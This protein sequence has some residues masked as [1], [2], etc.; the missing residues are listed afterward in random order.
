MSKGKRS[1]VVNHGTSS[2]SQLTCG[3]SRHQNNVK[4]LW[5]KLTKSRNTTMDS[6]FGSLESLPV[7]P[8]LEATEEAGGYD[9]E[10]DLA[11]EITDRSYVPPG[12]KWVTVEWPLEC[13]H[14]ASPPS[15]KWRILVIRD[16]EEEFEEVLPPDGFSITPRNRET[17]INAFIGRIDQGE[18]LVARNIKLFGRVP[19]DMGN[20]TAVNKLTSINGPIGIFRSMVH[21]IGPARAYRLICRAFKEPFSADEMFAW[22]ESGPDWT[23]LPEPDSESDDDQ[24]QLASAIIDDARV[25][26]DFQVDGDR[27]LIEEADIRDLREL[28]VRSHGDRR[29]PNLEWE[30]ASPSMSELSNLADDENASGAHESVVVPDPDLADIL[31]SE[32]DD[33][34]VEHLMQRDLRSVPEASP[35]ADDDNPGESQERLI[36]VRGRLEAMRELVVPDVD[37]EEPEADEHDE[38][39]DDEG[40]D[41]T[42]SEWYLDNL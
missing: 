39:A 42:D 7:P 33:P 38:E 17:G 31:T 15:W 40:T 4:K 3:Y 1:V 28:G 16:M 9:S 20:S 22:R 14:V 18:Y 6:G 41:S 8:E 35:E 10:P 36:Y 24:P 25:Y 23:L 37:D 11:R 19:D 13:D 30:L 27:I 5:Q 21:E 26:E 29:V 34:L 2:Q 12:F 32:E